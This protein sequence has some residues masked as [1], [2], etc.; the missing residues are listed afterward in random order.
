MTDAPEAVLFDLDNTLVP[1]LDPLDAWAAAWAR[2]AA[3]PDRVD[4]VK[5]ALMAATLDGPEDPDRAVARVTDRFDLAG[6][7]EHADAVAEKAY[8]DALS[9]YPGVC[10]VIAEIK[11]RGL[12]LGVVTDAP[13]ARA[14]HRLTATDLVHAFDVIVTRDD[15]PDGKQGPE[16]FET[17]LSVLGHRPE[18]AVMIG[19][20]PA[21]DVAWP[22]RLGMRAVLAGWGADPD[23]PRTGTGAPPCPVAGSPSEITTILFETPARARARARTAGGQAA[24]TAF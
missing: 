12:A 15:T 19:D 13:R 8:R 7:V 21:Y 18:R 23:D 4:E 14:M 9:P 24:L 17:A 3:A 2:A 5:D 20:W 16:P 11:R 6:P 1:F 22:R 10:G